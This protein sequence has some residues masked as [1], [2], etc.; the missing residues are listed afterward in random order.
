[1][2]ISNS[3]HLSRWKIETK[4]STKPVVWH[5]TPK[6]YSINTLWDKRIP[7]RG[8]CYL[9][10]T[11]RIL[12]QDA[13]RNNENFLARRC[14]L[15]LFSEL[16][17]PSRSLPEIAEALR[18]RLD[19]PSSAQ[20]LSD[21][22]RTPMTAVA[23]QWHSCC[24]HERT[25]TDSSFLG[26]LWHA[27]IMCGFAGPCGVFFCGCGERGLLQRRQVQPYQKENAIYQGTER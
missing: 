25:R 13:I 7:V 9:K 11:Q 19:S 10:I 12:S 6:I 27:A 14:W 23:N 26:R 15:S 5:V 16:F 18:L 8:L 22:A 24:V 17:E 21:S 4:I 2:G 3:R 20:S 1:M